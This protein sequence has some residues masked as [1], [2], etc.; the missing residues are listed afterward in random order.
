VFTQSNLIDLGGLLRPPF[1]KR[2]GR[3]LKMQLKS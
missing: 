1:G 2:I 3:L